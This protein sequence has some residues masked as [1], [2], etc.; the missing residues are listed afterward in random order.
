MDA[1]VDLPPISYEELVEKLT[2]PDSDLDYY[3]GYLIEDPADSIIAPQLRPDPELVRNVPPQLEGGFALGF[4]NWFMR[5]RRRRAYERRIRDGWAGPRIVSEGDSWF[6]YPT[7]LQDIIDH[8]MDDH[9]ILSLG[10]AGDELTDIRRQN[11]IVK[12]LK[13]EE[14]S[15]LLLSAGGNDLFDGG[16]LGDLVEAPFPGATGDQLVGA[17]FD[18]FLGSIVEDLAEVFHQALQERPYLHIL[19]HGYSPAFPRGGPWIERP[20]TRRGVLAETQHDVVKAMLRR[21]NDG[22]STLSARSEF[23]GQ[24]AHIDLTGIGTRR[25]DWHDEI[26]LDGTSAGQAADVF[27]EELARRLPVT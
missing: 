2:D 26:H 21:Y 22:L 3:Q 7:T 8:L 11:E 12:N 5:R 14:A 6:Q 18:A 15:A 20:L 9:A 23:N 13:T 4:A 19:V 25:N 10:A 24:V 16:Q 1:N 17:T 27:R